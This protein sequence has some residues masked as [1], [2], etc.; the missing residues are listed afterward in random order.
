MSTFSNTPQLPQPTPA[1]TSNVSGVQ[2]TGA[3]SGNTT[4]NPGAISTVLA[5]TSSQLTLSTG[6]GKVSIPSPR[7]TTVLDVGKDV[8]VSIDTEKSTAIL[9]V[10]AKYNQQRLTLTPQQSQQVL[11]TV[12]QNPASLGSSVEVKGRVISV[13]QNQIQVSVNGQSV[14]LSVRNPQQYQTG[15]DVKLSLS[16]GTLGWEATV[17][18]NSIKETFR[19]PQ[20]E[21]QKLLNS[22]RPGQPIELSEKGK[23]LIRPIL[24]ENSSSQLPVSL[25]KVTLSNTEGRVVAQLDIGGATIARLPLNKDALQ[26]LGKVELRA[27]SG[28][29]S[30]RDNNLQSDIRKLLGTQNQQVTA[31]PGANSQSTVNASSPGH[32]YQNPIK[33]SASAG[34]TNTTKGNDVSPDIAKTIKA[35]QEQFSDLGVKQKPVSAP[36][37]NEIKLGEQKDIRQSVQSAEPS[38]VPGKKSETPLSNSAQQILNTL[39]GL[40]AETAGE[41]RQTMLQNLSRLID[42]MSQQGKTASSP[43]Q[44][45]DILKLVRHLSEQ[46]SSSASAQSNSQSNNLLKA[47]DE[48]LASSGI[49]DS[50]KG[51][52]K[53]AITQV[54]PEQSGIPIPDM[55]GVKQLL[56]SATL[57]LTP[58]SI[59]TPAPSAGLVAGL[60][61]LLQVSLAARMNRGN[62]QVQDKLNNSLAGI[63]ASGAKA[64]TGN[65][66]G[67]QNM[68]ELSNLEQKH[69]LVKVLSDMVNQ[70]SQQK[71]QN[72]ERSLQGQEAMY[73]VLPFGS[74]DDQ[75]PAELLVQ[76]DKPEQEKHQEKQA[77]TKAWQL[78]M[79]LPVGELGEILT[80]SKVTEESI[81]VDLYTSS[82]ELK[83]LTMNYLPL[84]KRRFEVLGLNL[85]I[86]RCERG[87][88]P[89]QLAKNP[90][91]ILETR[92]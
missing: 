86:G 66:P 12:V 84:L 8:A 61:N 85:E 58:L 38:G 1:G 92:V 91:Q 64:Q 90:Y 39:K 17:Q 89:E 15:Q 19:L 35:S 41:V 88:I 51:H 27:N 68:R 23:Q 81:T 32:V 33:S 65:K 2:S 67:P 82:E 30:F 62:Q 52:I 21:S 28:V 60:V 55:Q 5:A 43:I 40:N 46:T 74:V 25:N 24:R 6:S 73:Y 13:Q 34:E 76:R 14:N 75:K 44:A 49:D 9:E 77:D 56:Q 80:K 11:Q 70:H 29:A 22:L 42:S 36:V 59:V 63:V 4:V 71:I 87:N 78:T 57:P 26:S 79:K 83:N 20:D 69:N 45:G 53:Q 54:K 31:Q 7:L 37:I 48:M 47:V 16:T 3:V 72:A 18:N 10:A 50:I